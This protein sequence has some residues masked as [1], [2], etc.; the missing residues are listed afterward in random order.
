MSVLV[1]KTLDTCDVCGYRGTVT[2]LTA[3]R[4]TLKFCKKCEPAIIKSIKI[5]ARELK[6]VML[7]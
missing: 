7:L 4:E 3:N 1:V 2:R 6:E 5:K